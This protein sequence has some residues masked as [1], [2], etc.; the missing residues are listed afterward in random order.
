MMQF[1]IGS[2]WY[3]KGGQRVSKV[4]TKVF[5]LKMLGYVVLLS[6]SFWGARTLYKEDEH[7]GHYG[8]YRKKSQRGG[9]F[10]INLQL[11]SFPCPAILEM[12]TKFWKQRGKQMSNQKIPLVSSY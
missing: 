1:G 6:G 8:Y 10:S 5:F 2:V 11:R 4:S 12:C 9:S 7:W 3:V